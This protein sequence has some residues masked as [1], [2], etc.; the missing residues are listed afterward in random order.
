M[1]LLARFFIIVLVIACAWIALYIAF[2][3]FLVI[4]IAAPFAYLYWRYKLH[5]LW[6]QGRGL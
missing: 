4:L 2:W 6:K 3:L 1:S 5:K